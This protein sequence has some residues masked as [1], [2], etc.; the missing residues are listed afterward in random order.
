MTKKDKLKLLSRTKQVLQ[1]DGW[2]QGMATSPSGR[3]CLMGALNEA[4]EQLDMDPR[5]LWIVE[6]TIDKA[7]LTKTRKTNL[8]MWISKWNDASGRTVDDVLKILDDSKK[9]I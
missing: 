1:D 2:C 4:S 8:D 3:H 5:E 6:E 9:Y 7:I